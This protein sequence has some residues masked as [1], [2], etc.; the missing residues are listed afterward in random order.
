MEGG[1]PPPLNWSVGSWDFREWLVEQPWFGNGMAII[2]HLELHSPPSVMK[3]LS[4]RVPLTIFP[5]RYEPGLERQVP[6][7]GGVPVVADADM[8]PGTTPYLAIDL[9]RLM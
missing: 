7:I 6:K 8:A 4:W 5:F 3:L 9:G 2:R 1:G